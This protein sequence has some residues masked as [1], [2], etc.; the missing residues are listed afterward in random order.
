MTL[1]I[2][3][4]DDAPGEKLDVSGSVQA[5]SGFKTAGHPIA[6][7]ASF[8]DIS[9]G[10][11]ATR[12]GSTGTSTLRSTQIY[13]GGSH[14]ATFD[15]VNT[16]LGIKVTNPDLTLHVNGVNSLPATSGTTPNG[17]LILRAKAQSSS[18]GMYMGVS[19]AS[20]WSS[21]I[22]AS[23]AN[24]LSTEYPLLLNPNGGS[25]I[26]N[27][28]SRTDSKTFL[29]VRSGS[30][31]TPATGMVYFK[32]D[33]DSNNPVLV[34]RTANGGNST[35]TMGLRIINT[36]SGNGLRVDADGSGGNPFIVDPQGY[37]GVGR[38]TPSTR[39]HI[40][41]N[42][43]VAYNRRVQNIAYNGICIDN[44]SGYTSG[45]VYTG[46]QFNNTGD[47]QNRICSI[48]MVS[49]ANNTRHSDMV[50]ATDDSGNREEKMRLTSNGTLHLHYAQEVSPNTSGLTP[51]L[52]TT[53]SVV[54]P[55]FWMPIRSP[56]SGFDADGPGYADMSDGDHINFMDPE[57]GVSYNSM[58]QAGFFNAYNQP[59]SNTTG[60]SEAKSWNRIRIWARVRR[61]DSSTHV[62]VTVKFRLVT[63]H[64]NT[65][66]KDQAQ[67]DW[68]GTDSARGGR[69][70]VSPW[71]SGSDMNSWADVPGFGLKYNN[72]GN[73]GATVR[74]QNNVHFQFAYFN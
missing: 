38:E 3:V 21:W 20:P 1:F 23:D 71:L 50:F 22:Q 19:G 64:Y 59:N 54:G 31:D 53:A 41:Q 15:G 7:Y 12:L 30:S 69:W 24:N 18:H 36:A 42:N 40:R 65:G 47:S 43:G 60:K 11:Y 2:R 49:K 28:T 10:S 74:I 72:N 4:S 51:Q 52:Q 33:Q 17:H 8:T 46:M 5:T 34:L 13:G 68:N 6:T 61:A 14:I 66:W 9:G 70:V 58:F 63:Y 45:G 56:S 32:V 25:V 16:R 27:A 37:V 39:L 44:A 26:V 35:D 57:V 29:E 55:M 67:W 62:Q 48:G 73:S